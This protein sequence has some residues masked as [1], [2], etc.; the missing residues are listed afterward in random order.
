VIDIKRI[1]VLKPKEFD[2]IGSFSNNTPGTPRG[3]ET[4]D[5]K[6]TQSKGKGKKL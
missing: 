6:E 4:G 5:G 1:D 2:N 3:I